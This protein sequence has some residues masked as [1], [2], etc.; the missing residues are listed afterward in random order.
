MDDTARMNDPN[1]VVNISTTKL[2]VADIPASIKIKGQVQEAWKWNDNLGENIF[3]T[4]YVLPMMT[5]IRR[6]ME[7]RAR[8][9]N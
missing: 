9:R 4:S 6:M 7:K 8:Q 5:R 1:Y 2:A 3:I